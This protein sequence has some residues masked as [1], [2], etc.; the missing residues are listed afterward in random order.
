MSYLAINTNK[1]LSIDNH[2]NTKIKLK[3]NS[4]NNESTGPEGTIPVDEAIAM[5]QNWRAYLEGSKQNFSAKSYL[6]PIIDFKNILKYNPDAESVRAYIGLE[7]V[8]DPMSSKLI[9]VPIVGGKDVIYKS[10]GDN[11]ELSSEADS[12]IYD[13]T[14]VCPPYC[15]VN[16]SPL[17]Q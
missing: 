5:T 11:S 10:T 15:D 9:L 14:R 12:N 17:N 16:D 7:N 8:N 2:H 3:M 6:I 1:K 13:L 4:I